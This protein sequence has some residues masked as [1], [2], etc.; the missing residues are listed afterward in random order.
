M[1]IL[2]DAVAYYAGLGITVC[3]LLT[4]NGSAFRSREFAQAF[5]ALGIRQVYLRLQVADQWQG[6]TPRPISLER[7]GLCLDLSEFP[8]AS[9]NANQ[10]A[11]SLQQAL[12]T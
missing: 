5:Q 3:R 7:V 8:G 10:L 6:R 12:T 4:D 9:S 1:R 11:T 2:P